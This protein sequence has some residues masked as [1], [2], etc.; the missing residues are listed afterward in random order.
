M[1]GAHSVNFAGYDLSCYVDTVDI[2]HGRDDTTNQPDAS[3]ATITLDLEDF[4]LP[5][6]VEV[7]GSV[8][9]STMF[10]SWASTRFVGRITDIALGWDDAGEDTPNAGIGQIVATGILSEIGRRVVGD[11]PFPQELDG[12]RVTR[13]MNL[14]NIS[15]DPLYSDPGTVEILPR[16]IDATDALSVASEAATS[17]MGVLWQTKDGEVRYADAQHR[18]NIPASIVLDACDVLVTPTWSRTIQ[19]LINKVS[20]GWGVAAEGASDQP[21]VYAQDDDSIFNF[22]VYDF[23]VSTVIANEDDAKAQA[24]FLVTLNSRPVWIMTDLPVDMAGLD[25][26]QT[27]AVLDLDMHALVILTGLPVIAQH[28]DTTANLWVEGWQEHLEAGVHELTLTVSGYCRTAPPP[29][30]DE[31]Q[32]AQT[33]DSMGEITWNDIACLGPPLPIGRW[34][35]VPA[36]YRWDLVPPSGTWDTWKW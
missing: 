19:G 21:R 33:W 7:G 1:I 16:D 34:A 5:D 23:S 25:L 14:A 32:P 2:N 36:S 22:G 30:W 9:V 17:G 26:A 6:Y 24:L 27:Q 10:D 31:M 3:S 13:V 4:P 35:D 8:T 18:K 12:A 15:L 28:G 11:A 20:L 29:T